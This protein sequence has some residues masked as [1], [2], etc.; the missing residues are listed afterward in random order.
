MAGE[1]FE[2]PLTYVARR[3]IDTKSSLAHMLQHLFGADPTPGPRM[4]E[5]TAKYMTHHSVDIFRSSHYAL[6][7]LYGAIN[8]GQ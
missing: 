2:I 3:L 8:F 5:L 7:M 6:V 1:L 4:S